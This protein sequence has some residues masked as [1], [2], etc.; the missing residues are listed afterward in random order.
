ML[1]FFGYTL[2]PYKIRSPKTEIKGGVVLT[3]F[4]YFLK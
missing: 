1:A 3:I 4:E 2:P